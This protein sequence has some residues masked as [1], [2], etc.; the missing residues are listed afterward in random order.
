[1]PLLLALLLT[2]LP[3]AAAGPLEDYR[4]QA[5]EQSPA[6]Q[7]AWSRWQAAQAAISPARTLPEPMLDMGL[8]LRSGQLRLGLSQTFPWPTELQAEGQAATAEA[9]AAQRA[10][11]AQAVE[12]AGRVEQTYWELWENRS[13]QAVLVEH[14]AVL[15]GLS[16]ATR[17]RLEVGQASLADVQ[18]VDLAAARLEDNRLLL[19]ARERAG[20]AELRALLGRR[21][22]EAMPT[23]SLRPPLA[24]PVEGLGTLEAAALQHPR[25]VEAEQMV[26][27]AEAM[28]RGARAQR[29][30]ELTVGADWTLPAP[31]AAS[32]HAEPASLMVGL[33]LSLPLWQRSYAQGIAAAKAEVE[34]QRAQQR[35]MGDEALAALDA[36]LADLADSERRARLTEDALLPQAQ[37]ALDSLLGA[38]STDRGSLA[39]VLMAQREL[40]ELR[41][42]ADMA[43]AAHARAWAALEQLC[44]RP[45]TRTGD[46]G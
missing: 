3:A 38:L 35:G 19:V 39:Q 5:Q 16:R 22:R 27:R 43:R 42:E 10:F 7:S 29:A 34:A 37:A 18:Q 26:A 6:L 17:A 15:A 11:E 40:L 33:G 21:D 20:E 23:D 24:L 2:L 14:G 1:M 46:A 36:T 9:M 12:V 28:V 30:P 45:L 31:A 32:D 8:M 13:A 41:L 44:G 4:L 25:L